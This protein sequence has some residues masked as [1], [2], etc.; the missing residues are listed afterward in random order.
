MSLVA[1]IFPS[2]TQPRSVDTNVRK[3]QRVSPHRKRGVERI[4]PAKHS[5]SWERYKPMNC[6][7]GTDCRSSWTTTSASTSEA[8][9]FETEPQRTS[10]SQ[11]TPRNNRWKCFSKFS[12]RKK[13]LSLQGGNSFLEERCFPKHTMDFTK[14]YNKYFLNL[15]FR[16]LLEKTRWITVLLSLRFWNGWRLTTRRNWYSSRIHS[17]LRRANISSLKEYKKNGDRTRT[18]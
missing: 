10:F 4:A 9:L 2:R 7:S 3:Y 8:N 15:L 12:D 13:I 14:T 5:K 6:A 11:Q 18:K 17:E 16:T 1:P